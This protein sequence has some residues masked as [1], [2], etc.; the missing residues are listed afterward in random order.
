MDNDALDSMDQLQRTV[1]AVADRLGRLTPTAIQDG[2]RGG[3]FRGS[4]GVF[5]SHDADQ[6]IERRTGIAARQRTDFCDGLSHFSNHA[7]ANRKMEHIRTAPWRRDPSSG[8]RAVA[9]SETRPA[10]DAWALVW[11]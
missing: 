10:A 3:Y 9:L 2:I 11:A 5:R 1:V 7:R 4:S 8:H 6:D